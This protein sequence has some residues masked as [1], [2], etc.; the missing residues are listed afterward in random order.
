MVGSKRK[1]RTKRDDFFEEVDDEDDGPL[2]GGSEEEQMSEEL[3]SEEEKETAEE[4]RLRMG[5]Y[6]LL[7]Y[8]DNMN[9]NPIS[10]CGLNGKKERGCL[11]A[12]SQRVPGSNSTG[13]RGAWGRCCGY[14]EAR[15]LRIHGP[16]QAIGCGSTQTTRGAASERL[17]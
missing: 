5:E 17:F 13:E 6:V 11:T 8:I 3:E 15:C 2:F 1:L 7:Y 16:F 4:K 12:C 14:S 10:S 9:Y